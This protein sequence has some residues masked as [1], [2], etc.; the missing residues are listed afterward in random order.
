MCRKW[1]GGEEDEHKLQLTGL[2]E[3]DTYW[4]FLTSFFS[5]PN[6]LSA[7]LT[8]QLSNSCHLSAIQSSILP[9]LCLLYPLLF[10]ISLRLQVEVE[11]LSQQ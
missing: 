1:F 2:D 11:A 10:F 9:T 5:L 4:L 8:I 7:S 3:L 6:K